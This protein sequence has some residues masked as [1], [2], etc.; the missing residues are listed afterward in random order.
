M[1][2]YQPRKTVL[3]SYYFEAW[4]A[5]E[6]SSRKNGALQFPPNAF[7]REW[8]CKVCKETCSCRSSSLWGFS[9]IEQETTQECRIGAHLVA[10]DK[11]LPFALALVCTPAKSFLLH[12]SSNELPECLVPLCL[13]KILLQLCPHSNELLCLM[14]TPLWNTVL[15]LASLSWS[16]GPK[17]TPTH[18]WR[19]L[20]WQHG[21]HCQ[22]LPHQPSRSAWVSQLG[23]PPCSSTPNHQKST[24][25][26]PAVQS[27]RN[28]LLKIQSLPISGSENI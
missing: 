24:S 9:S 25:T 16:Q 12:F 28:F 3:L 11:V 21:H 15:F 5:R 7:L 18:L 8:G 19:S 14:V 22:I 26:S 2:L 1:G 27:P 6:W 10:V 13:G 20:H 4:E 23:L 17:V